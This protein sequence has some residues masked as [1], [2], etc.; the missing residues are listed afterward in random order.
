MRGSFLTAPPGVTPRQ[1]FL[2]PALYLPQAPLQLLRLPRLAPPTKSTDLA[3]SRGVVD[4]RG[5]SDGIAPDFPRGLSL[6]EKWRGVRWIVLKKSLLEPS[7]FP[8]RFLDYLVMSA[9][10]SHEVVER[11]WVAA[12]AHRDQ[13]VNLELP[14]AVALVGVDAAV[15]VSC[16]CGLAGLLPCVR[17]EHLPVRIVGVALCG[18]R[19]AGKRT[20]CGTV[21]TE[22][23]SGVVAADGDAAAAALTL[24]EPPGS[25]RTPKCRRKNSSRSHGVSSSSS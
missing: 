20:M 15:P 10:D 25:R 1:S 14:V 3:P 13:M 6:A 2:P 23:A 24:L 7:R 8:L 16:S 4:L 17:A 21:V 11:E 12:A 9:A 5:R 22:P 18:A 19:S